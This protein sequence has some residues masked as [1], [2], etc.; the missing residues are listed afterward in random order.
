VIEALLD[1]GSPWHWAAVAV[2]AISGAPCAF[3]GLRD[4]FVRRELET[5][6][7]KLTGARAMAAGAVYLAFG[8]AGIAGA[9]AFVARGR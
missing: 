3:I 8:L 6:G 7:G 4:G 2:L 1:R 9:I 5:N